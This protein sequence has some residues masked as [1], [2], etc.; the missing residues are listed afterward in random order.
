MPDKGLQLPHVLPS[1]DQRYVHAASA[2]QVGKRIVGK[3]EKDVRR[4]AAFLGVIVGRLP[5]LDRAELRQQH[6]LGLAK[7]GPLVD[8]ERRPGNAVQRHVAKG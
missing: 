2:E 6:S 7:N 3:G 4:L 5:A 1:S 8:D